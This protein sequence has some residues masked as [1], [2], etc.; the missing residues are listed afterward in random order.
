MLIYLETSIF[1]SPAQ[2]LVNTVNTVG[3]MGKGIAATF[4]KLYPKMF[5]EYYQ[6]CLS[7]EFDIGKLYIYKTPNIVIVNFPTKKHWRNPS[8]IE[9]IQAG[10]EKFVTH[11]LDFGFSSIS[12]PQ[13]GC[14]HG[15]LK[16]E[17]QVQPLME[18][19]LMHLPIPVYIHLYKK[20]EDFIPERLDKKYEHQASIER[21]LISNDR[22]WND[23]QKITIGEYPKTNQ[24][25]LFSPNILVYDK[26]ISFTYA[27]REP[28]VLYREDIEDFWNIL[29]V[30]GTASKN[31]VPE[32]IR[33]SGAEEL[34]INL[35]EK[36]NYV[37]TINLRSPKSKSFSKGLQYNPEPNLETNNEAD[38]IV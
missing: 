5:Q 26:F 21:E 13:L 11:Y 32:S 22:F 35:M 19:Y 17:G 16:W 27:E 6:L 2:A 14:G 36:L 23:L 33:Q 20:P 12:F 1:D 38:I 9:Y 24:M 30:R 4:K 28:I 31:D 8:R 10:L 25:T 29:R 15:E 34:L 18:E 3:V 37:R 7:G